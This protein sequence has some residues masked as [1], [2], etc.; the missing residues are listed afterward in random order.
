[1]KGC[2][3]R[4]RIIAALAAAAVLG[5]AA[6][7]YAGGAASTRNIFIF[8]SAAGFL[9][10]NYNHRARL[11]REQHLRVERRQEAYWDWYYHKFGYYPTQAQF[12]KWYRQ[13]YGVNPDST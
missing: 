6:P 5:S 1:M 3:N 4:Q 12:D 10:A 2:F 13:T 8:G 9:I 7:A 11:Q